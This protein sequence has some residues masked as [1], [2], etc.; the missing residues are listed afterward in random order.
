M[1]TA[2]TDTNFENVEDADAF[3]VGNWKLEIRYWD[4][5]VLDIGILGYW[6]GAKVGKSTQPAGL[7]R[8]TG[9]PVGLGRLLGVSN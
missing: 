2:G 4:I 5:G 6:G 7:E 8:E 1:R 3:H 9:I